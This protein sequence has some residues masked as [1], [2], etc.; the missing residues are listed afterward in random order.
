MREVTS[1]ERRGINNTAVY[2]KESGGG[3][4]SDT[5]GG[6]G[7][8]APF[9]RRQPEEEDEEDHKS[10]SDSTVMMSGNSPFVSKS[11]RYNFLQ[12]S[13]NMSWAI[14]PPESRGPDLRQDCP[15]QAHRGRRQCFNL[16]VRNL[17]RTRIAVHIY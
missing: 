13:G 6:P 7:A 17:E 14:L 12:R 5:E 8:A 9:R 1:E 16:G 10:D 11:A 2:D 3:G 4:C 15:V